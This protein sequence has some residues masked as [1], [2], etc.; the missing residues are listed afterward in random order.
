MEISYLDVGE[1]LTR[2]A[3]TGPPRPALLRVQQGT[4]SRARD[5]QPLGQ[6]TGKPAPPNDHVLCTEF[7]SASLLLLRLLLVPG[8]AIRIYSRAVFHF[9][10]CFAIY[11]H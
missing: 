3:L 8:R 4:H 6:P 9:G 2:T 1:Q 11:F 10:K 5:G 7:F